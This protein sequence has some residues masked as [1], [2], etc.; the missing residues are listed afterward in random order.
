MTDLP[1]LT[2]GAAPAMLAPAKP[3][4]HRHDWL[5]YENDGRTWAACRRCDAV[6]NE[7]AARRGRN[8][9]ARGKRVERVE[10]RR[11]GIHTGNANGADDGLSEDGRFAYQAKA[12]SSARFPSWMT[13]EL[14]KLRTARQDKAPVLLVA[15]TPGSGRKG[16]RIAV[17][18]WSTWLDEHGAP[19]EEGTAR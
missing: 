16:R 3:K 9:R 13:N 2:D 10:M 7:T 11:A 5:R 14:D 19:T 1:F 15:E 17:V 4:P 12:M 18:D 6:R 8:N